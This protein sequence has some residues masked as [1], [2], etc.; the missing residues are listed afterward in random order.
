MDSIEDM[1]KAHQVLLLPEILLNICTLMAHQDLKS[2]RLVSHAWNNSAQ[3]ILF[4]IVNLKLNGP[5]FERLQ[6]IAQH[7]E[8]SKYVRTVRYDARLLVKG[9]LDETLR[10]LTLD[11]WLEHRAAAHLLTR[12]YT[13]EA[14]L[15]RFKQSQ[16]EVYYHN[17]LRFVKGQAYLCRNNNFNE[18]K[19]LLNALPKLP[20][21]TGIYFDRPKDVWR[22]AESS[23]ALSTLSQIA[24]EILEEPFYI[25]RQSFWNLLHS[26]TFFYN[27]LQPLT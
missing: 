9:D 1:T 27:F 13:G 5:S 14:F 17:Y 12:N 11:Y 19:L 21:L 25:S 15:S 2:A 7:E 26:G 23:Q 10:E 20:R 16:L 3:V 22:I 24:Q 8:L 18:R 4:E 6:K